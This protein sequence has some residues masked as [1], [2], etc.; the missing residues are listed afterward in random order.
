MRILP[1]MLLGS[2]LVASGGCSMLGL[3]RET[4]ETAAPAASPEIRQAQLVLQEQGTYNGRVDG[5]PGPATQ[6]S[7]RLY[8]Q[9]HKLDAT[10]QLDAAT[11]ASLKLRDNPITERPQTQMADGS[12]MSESDA[13]KLIESQGFTKVSDLYR[14][15]SAVWRGMASRGGKASEVAIDAR[16]NVVTN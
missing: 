2:L 5:V 15:D 6:E 4:H 10:G 8:Q 9:A 12:K 14:D 1:I 16:G 11:R 7:I 13:R 3:Q